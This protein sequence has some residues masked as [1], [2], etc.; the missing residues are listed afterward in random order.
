MVHAIL[1]TTGCPSQADRAQSVRIQLNRPLPK[2][3]EARLDASLE[4]MK[5]Q[6]EALAGYG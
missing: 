1:P 6:K 2:E 5:G 4:Q 3:A